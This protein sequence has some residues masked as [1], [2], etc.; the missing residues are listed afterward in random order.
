[1]IEQPTPAEC[2]RPIE[3]VDHPPPDIK[4]VPP[5][6]SPDVEPQNGPDRG[7]ATPGDWMRLGSDEVGV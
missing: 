2:P 4:P 6:D 1:M 7:T 3:P 5:P